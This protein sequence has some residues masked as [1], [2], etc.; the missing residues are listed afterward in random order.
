MTSPDI[1]DQNPYSTQ[2]YNR[3]SYVT[4]N[5]LKYVDPSG[6]FRMGGM[7]V[8]PDYSHIHANNYGGND[9]GEG[10]MI[11]RDFMDYESYL[12]NIFSNQF[13]PFWGAA[14][15]GIGGGTLLLNKLKE[16]GLIEGGVS[17]NDPNFITKVIDEMRN[18]KQNNKEGNISSFI[19]MTSIEFTNY[20]SHVSSTESYKYDGEYVEVTIYNPNHVRDL[21]YYKVSV[22]NYS[23]F[24]RVSFG[25]ISISNQYSL[26][27][28]RIYSLELFN[29]TYNYIFKKQ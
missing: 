10:M 19:D 13:D 9:V 16:M 24:G 8:N 12:F 23:T 27:S 22:R 17:I 14:G 5:P 7:K 25:T 11:G 26:L 28:L 1:L 4:N 20:D 21:D 15:G 2:S 29:K 3:Y 6:Y 18:I